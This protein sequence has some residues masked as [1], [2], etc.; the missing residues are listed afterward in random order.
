MAIGINIHHL[1]LLPKNVLTFIFRVANEL[2][3]EFTEKTVPQSGPAMQL[4]SFLICSERY[5]NRI[6]LYAISK[7]QQAATDHCGRP[8]L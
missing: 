7:Y 1:A 8:R 3:T 2:T 5:Y 6:V 4:Q